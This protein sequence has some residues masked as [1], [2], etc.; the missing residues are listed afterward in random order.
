[1]FE[2]NELFVTVNDVKRLAERLDRCPAVTRF[3]SGEHREAWA[4]ADAFAELEKLMRGVLGTQ[5]PRITSGVLSEAEVS[6]VLLDIGE[7]F[8]RILYHMLEEPHFFRYLVPEG[9][10]PPTPLAEPDLPDPA[11]L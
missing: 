6:D 11:E 10:L 9:P 5:L 8:R 7:E 2:G 4:I 1:M 3:D